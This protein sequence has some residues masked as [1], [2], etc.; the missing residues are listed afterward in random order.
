MKALK[1]YGYVLGI[2]IAG[3]MAF[4]VPGRVYASTIWDPITTAADVTGL[5]TMQIT[6]LAAIIVLPLGLAGFRVIKGALGY[7]GG[8]R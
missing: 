1:E 5:S 4:V 2:V 7:V 8:R 3:L 6:L